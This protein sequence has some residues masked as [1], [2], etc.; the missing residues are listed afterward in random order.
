MDRP[1]WAALPELLRERVEAA[2]PA[3][4]LW[5]IRLRVGQKMQ[6][7]G[8]G[9]NCLCGEK[10][11]QKPLAWMGSALME[12]SLYAWEDELARGYFTT[13]Q[14]FRVGV[15]GKYRRLDGRMVL[16]DVYSL[17]IRL[18]KEAVGCA[19]PLI[20]MLKQ[21]HSCLIL[22]APGCGKTTLLR[23]VARQ[24]SN[25]G[26]T[27]AVLDERCEIAAAWQGQP[28]MDVGERTDVIEGVDKPRGIPMIVRALSP[29]T[30]VTDELGGVD[31]AE[32]IADAMRCG[33]QVVATAHAGSLADAQRRTA[34]A[35]LLET[36]FGMV[37]ELTEPPG[38]LRSVYR[39]EADGWR[40][41]PV[42]GGI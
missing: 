13:R 11:P 25:A 34:L 40:N 31:D 6:L 32:A 15:A 16:Q 29:Q 36:G 35:S 33:V 21:G 4:E 38:T 10:I 39:R 42:S 23:D 28:G 8:R 12:H 14:G 41:V 2:A 3:D 37:V 5:E 1:A 26:R 19:D 22:S 17:C 30:L 20:P 9:M 27:V 18:A 24:L 7:I